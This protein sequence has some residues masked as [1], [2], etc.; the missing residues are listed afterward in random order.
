MRIEESWERFEKSTSLDLTAAVGNGPVSVDVNA[1]QSSQLRSE[2][3]SYYA[4][5]N[6]FIPLWS[7]YIPDDQGFHHSEL[8]LE[9]PTPY[10]PAARRTYARF[11]E[12]FGTH[13]IRRVWVGGKAMLAFTVAKS[14]SMSK[15]DIKAGI[16]ASFVGAGSGAVN[17]SSD[18]A[19][20]CVGAS[21]SSSRVTF[22]SG[23][24]WKPAG[25]AVPGSTGT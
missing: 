10:N 17:A 16:K 6:S 4:L 15:E 14:S 2:E 23:V 21:A 5:R 18:S 19:K 25:M 12:R 9:I 22:G 24:G 20:L 8:D 1:S 11:F 3:D 13:Y 7:V